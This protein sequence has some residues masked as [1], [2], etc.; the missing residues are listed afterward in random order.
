MRTLLT[1]ATLINCVHPTAIPGTAV[2]IEDGR[3]RE[4]R[5]DGSSPEA[6]DARLIDLEGAYLMPGL[7]DV[8]I[9]PDYFL[10]HEMPLADQVTLFGHRLMAALS[11]SGITG[12]RC[13]GAHHYMDVAWK[14]AFDSGQYVGPRLFASGHFLT[15]TAGHFLTS[16]HALEV[17]GPYGFVKAIREQIKNGVDHIKLNLSGGILGP[18][19]DLHRHSFL[20]QDELRAAF[21]ICHLREFKVMAHATNPEAVKNAIRLGAHSVEHGYILDD[22]CIE[23]FLKHDTWYVPTLAISHLTPEQADNDF[24][25]RWVRQR[26]MAHALCC[27]ADAAS[28]VHRDG[29]TK[30][31]KAGVK[32][33]LGSDIRP[34][35][36]AA[37]LELG[38]WV[39]DGATPWQALVAATR[40][41]AAICGVG[42][43]LGTIEVGKL[44]D[45]IV[46]DGNPL[47]DIQNVRKLKLVL[48]EGVVVSDKRR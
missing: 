13:A 41:G 27:R 5:S 33:A 4:I 20:L 24:E 29:F 45:L 35:K 7:W 37:L 34:L 40:N 36:D 14:R 15:T 28:D 38:L 22:E 3:I 48:K 19:W 23:L 31:L 2:L 44:A 18:A 12:L 21:E 39:R 43:E 47:E 6:G 26:N 9:H 32:M 11:E 46:V 1:N 16:G 42:H 17:D 25:Q 30:A 10:P 8:H